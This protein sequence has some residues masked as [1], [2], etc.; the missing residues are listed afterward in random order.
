M[1]GSDSIS[2]LILKFGDH[3]LAGGYFNRQTF[4]I[5]VFIPLNPLQKLA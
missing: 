3:Q 2:L 5:P 1:S 4:R